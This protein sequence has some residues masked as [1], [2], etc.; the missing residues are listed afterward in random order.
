MNEKLIALAERRA[1]LVA[2]SA[3]QRTEL[4]QVMAP[5]KTRLGWVDHGLSAMRY[6]GEHT[7]LVAGALGIVTILSPKRVFGWLRRGWLL[8]RAAIAVQRRLF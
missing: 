6:I 7:A 5:W 3:N 4:A 8:W 2:R 1:L